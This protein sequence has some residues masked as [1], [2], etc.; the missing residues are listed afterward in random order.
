M[1][2][3]SQ[4]WRD[5]ESIAADALLEMGDPR[6]GPRLQMAT[7]RV[8]EVLFEYQWRA[9]TETEYD[10]WRKCVRRAAMEMARSGQMP[11][12]ARLSMWAERRFAGW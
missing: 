8:A 2:A 4:T 12:G 6:L 10:R 11:G 3:Q 5:A 7:E 1:I 9:R